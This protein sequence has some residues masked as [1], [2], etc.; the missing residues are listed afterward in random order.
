MREGLGRYRVIRPPVRATH[1]PRPSFPH[2]RAAPQ[3]RATDSD[4][5][6]SLRHREHGY[7]PGFKFHDAP[8]ALVNFL[9][10]RAPES[11]L[12]SSLPI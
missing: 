4:A 1:T 11:I 3:P 2:H 8:E 6:G 12:D 5:K 9:R 10:S 7:D